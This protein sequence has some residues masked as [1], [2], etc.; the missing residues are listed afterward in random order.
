MITLVIICKEVKPFIRR[1]KISSASQV[2]L[3][4]YGVL[5]FEDKVLLLVSKGRSFEGKFLS[6]FRKVLHL[7]RTGP[8]SSSNML[9]E[10]SILGGNML[11][12]REVGLAG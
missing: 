8:A 9:F 7:T 12:S 2:L 6:L 10:C 11:T 1:K 3:S 4:V 5:L